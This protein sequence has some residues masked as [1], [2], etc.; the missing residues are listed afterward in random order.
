MFIHLIFILPIMVI[1]KGKRDNKRRTE[2]SPG[3]QDAPGATM[4]LLCR[5]GRLS[6]CEAQLETG[7]L[8]GGRVQARQP[9][10]EVVSAQR[11]GGTTLP[12]MAAPEHDAR[13]MNCNN[14]H[15]L[16]SM[17]RDLVSCG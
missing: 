13:F 16:I 1:E 11:K 12:N 8:S 7:G 5:K 4:L 9:A 2:D 6:C 3:W 10:R 14:N 15:L 17:E